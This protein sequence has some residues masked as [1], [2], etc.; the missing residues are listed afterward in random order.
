MLKTLANIDE[1][2]ESHKKNGYTMSTNLN[3]VITKK[4]DNKIN[5]KIID[6]KYIFEKTPKN[7]KNKNKNYRAPELDNKMPTI[8]ES[9]Y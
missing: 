7:N 5:K 2:Q 3:K 1:L 9:G 4:E 6:P 8:K